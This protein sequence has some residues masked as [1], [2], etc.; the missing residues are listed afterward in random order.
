MDLEQALRGFYGAPPPPPAPSAGVAKRR[1]P[2]VGVGASKEASTRPTFAGDGREAGFFDAPGAASPSSAYRGAGAVGAPGLMPPAFDGGGAAFYSTPPAVSAAPERDEYMNGAA[3][4]RAQEG[5]A[6]A[7]ASSAAAVS[8][9]SSS[10]QQAEKGKGKRKKKAVAKA[11]E[12]A[13][14]LEADPVG[15]PTLGAQG[16]APPPIP[17][18]LP[19]LRHRDPA[20]PHAA[21]LATTASHYAVDDESDGLES[22]DVSEDERYSEDGG[23]GS[24][25]NGGAVPPAF[26]DAAGP[27]GGIPAMT[28]DEVMDDLVIRFVANVPGE[29]LL[30]FERICFLVEQAHWCYID[31]YREDHPSLPGLGA[32]AFMK[33][34]FKRTP[35]LAPY[36]ENVEELYS[37]F[38]T[39]KQSVPTYGVIILD[40]SLTKC[41]MVQGWGQKSW[42]FP[43]GKVNVGEEPID[44]AARE[45]EEEV[46]INVRDRLRENC[47]IDLYMRGRLNSLYIAPGVPEDTEFV[48]Q[49]RKEIQKIEWH[50]VASLPENNTKNNHY[51]M[52]EPYVR[53]LKNWIKQS[54][55]E[56]RSE[57]DRVAELE[58]REKEKVKMARE[59][60]EAREEVQRL[61]LMRRIQ[62]LEAQGRHEE[63]AQLRAQLEASEPVRDAQEEADASR[64]RQMEAMHAAH[65][66]HAA[67]H[68]AK[69][70]LDSKASNKARAAPKQQREQHAARESSRERQAARAL[71]EQRDARAVPD[72]RDARALRGQREREMQEHD[73]ELQ[74]ALRVRRE[75]ATMQAQMQQQQ[76]QLAEQQ[77]KIAAHEAAA[78]R[79][80]QEL[81][82]GRQSS[83]SMSQGPGAGANQY[84]HQFAG[85]SPPPP[86]GAYMQVPPPQ[87]VQ[88]LQGQMPPKHTQGQMPPP[89]MQGQMHPPQMQGQMPPPQMQGQMPPP[90]MQGQMHPPQM[91]GQMPPLSSEQRQIFMQMQQQQMQQQ[92]QQMQMQQIQH[93]QM[94]QQM[95]QLQ[96]QR[97]M[98][99][100]QAPM[101]QYP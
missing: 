11:A 62:A 64:R 101:Q 17:T 37:R 83:G 5:I 10:G 81:A 74:D 53:R 25:S 43:K 82:L 66:A 54:R 80:M 33:A 51:Y 7:A 28:L 56:A 40:P 36:L 89:H 4:V 94:R 41:L 57:A 9:A 26:E 76:Q 13:A 72:Q 20:A 92:Q 78:Q 29:E 8:A 60:A 84:A 85:H 65:A 99:Q 50:T 2:P 44:C 45:A 31:F 32:K 59:Q 49:T 1:D 96:M 79:M 90:H 22:L 88:Q 75:M 58:E 21:L 23:G 39:Y 97:Q 19:G 48:T 27:P 38:T 67:Q 69:G 68:T 47:K 15:V 34:L 35:L 52:V 3:R 93:Q 16:R 63:V 98:Q 73:R 100:H 24:R 86:G 42:G 91:Q 55:R 6:T 77:A 71:P 18:S 61:M 87:M 70:K 30:E 46:G 12:A 14:P 95:Q